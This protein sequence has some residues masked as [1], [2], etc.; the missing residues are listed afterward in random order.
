MTLDQLLTRLYY[1]PKSSAAFGGVQR[2]FQA[3]KRKKKSVT[4]D[5]VQDWLEGQVTY[6]LHKPV[7]HRFKRR[8]V[9]VAGIDHQWQADLA[10]LSSLQKMNDGYRYLLCVIDVFSKYAWVVPVKNK[11]GS[12]MIQAWDNILKQGRHPLQLQTDKGTEFLNKDFQQHLKKLD[13]HF[14]TTENPEIKAGIVERFQRSLKSRMWKYFTHHKTRQYVDVLQ[15]LVHGY[16]HAKHRSIGRSPASVSS[17][18]EVEVTEKLYGKKPTF[19]KPTLSVGDLVR[20]NKTKRTFDKGYL[21]N[22]TTELFKITHVVK[23]IPPTYKIEDLLGEPL[24]GT[25]Y[26]KEIQRVK[27]TEQVYEI[28]EILKHRRRR[29]GKRWVKEILVSWKDYPSKFNS[30]ILESYLV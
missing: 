9:V 21:P 11:Q 13:I 20:L 17:K 4:F 25:F 26:A 6:T 8:R 18:N 10:D 16:N 19:T 29:Q 5:Q 14:F 1:H 22:W 3:A 23:S 2:L 28:D 7:R 15:D 12:T 27:D 30:W 24:I